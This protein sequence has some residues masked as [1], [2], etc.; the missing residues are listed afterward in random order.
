M[1]SR[2]ALKSESAFEKMASENVNLHV[3]V[4]RL[5]D[6]NDVLACKL[7]LTDEG[8]IVEY[9]VA[10]TT[11]SVSYQDLE[12]EVS[13]LRGLIVEVAASGIEYEDTGIAYKSIQ[14]NCDLWEELQS[15]GE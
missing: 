4:E 7:G 11:P 12:A 1:T 8:T 9:S 13:R 14:I 10:A 6:A 5:R 3:E 2:P 15:V